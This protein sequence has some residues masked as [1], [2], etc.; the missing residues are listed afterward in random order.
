LLEMLKPPCSGSR[1][2]GSKGPSCCSNSSYLGFF[3]KWHPKKRLKA[4]QEDSGKGL[5]K[6]WS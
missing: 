3:V 6:C 1:S 4:F 2:K 5:A